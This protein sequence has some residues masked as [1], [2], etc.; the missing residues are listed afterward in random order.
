MSHPSQP[1]PQELLPSVHH[2]LQARH[3]THSNH[4]P[5]VN[6]SG[7][8][9]EQ[10]TCTAAPQTWNKREQSPTAHSRTAWYGGMWHTP[11]LLPVKVLWQPRRI[12]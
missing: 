10:P 2:S 8:E 3:I 9:L 4:G 5:A 7:R 1:T 11:F 6:T 12:V